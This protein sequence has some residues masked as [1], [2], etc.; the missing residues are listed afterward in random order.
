LKEEVAALALAGA[1]QVLMREVD[2]NA[3]DEILDK[4]SSKL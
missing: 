3:H 1:E 2:K 4:I